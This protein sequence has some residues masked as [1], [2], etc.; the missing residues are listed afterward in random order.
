[1]VNTK[2]ILTCDSFTSSRSSII[3]VF[4]LSNSCNFQ[5]V[6]SISNFLL[7]FSFCKHALKHDNGDQKELNLF[8]EMD[9]FLE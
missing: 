3:N 8:F 6:Q 1:M 4:S 9:P 2:T 7:A 5:I